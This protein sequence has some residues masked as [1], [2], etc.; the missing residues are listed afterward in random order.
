MITALAT[1]IIAAGQLQPLVLR[2]QH[3]ERIASGAAT[4][5]LVHAPPPLWRRDQ[6]PE[7][8]GVGTEYA[9]P[10]AFDREIG[11][12]ADPDAMI[13]ALQTARTVI[14]VPHA[15]IAWLEIDGVRVTT[16]PLLV[17]PA[18]RRFGLDHVTAR[19]RDRDGDG[20]LTGIDVDP[21]E[22]DCPP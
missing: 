2:G 3:L 12:H 20:L 5:R 15:W 19:I 1:P 14:T 17:L 18:A 16:L 13:G 21:V 11:V 6:R 22:S 4:V 8:E 7:L 10:L 9:L